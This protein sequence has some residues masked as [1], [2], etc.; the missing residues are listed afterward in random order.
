MDLGATVCV[1]RA[2]ACDACQIVRSCATK[3]P[4]PD[5][6]RHRQA[7]YAGSFRQ[8]RGVVLARLREGPTRA[9]E[10]DGEALASL[11]DDGLAEVT[12]GRAHLPKS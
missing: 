12:R 4:R 8:R 5:E 2:P 11:L 1:A 10:L 6:M 7:P 9:I 3:G